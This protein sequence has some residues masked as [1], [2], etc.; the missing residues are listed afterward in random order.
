MVAKARKRK[1]RYLRHIRC[2]KNEDGRLLTQDEIILNIWMDYFSKLFNEAHTSKTNLLKN[3]SMIEGITIFVINLV[4]N[5]V[6]KR[7]IKS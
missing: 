6:H 3:I 7:L 1:T 2:I 5:L 4:Q